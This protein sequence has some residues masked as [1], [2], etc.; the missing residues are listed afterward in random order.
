MWEGWRR[1][2]SPYPDPG[3]TAV[4]GA[5]QPSREPLARQGLLASRAL[6]KS[7]R[8]VQAR[9]RPAHRIDDRLVRPCRRSRASACSASSRAQCVSLPAQSRNELRSKSKLYALS[10]RGDIVFARRERIQ[11]GGGR[12]YLD[13]CRRD[14]DAPSET[15]ADREGALG[16]GAR[17]FAVFQKNPGPER[18]HAVSWTACWATV[19]L[20][21]QPPRRVQV[22]GKVR[23]NNN[24]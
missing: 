4:F 20:L 1:E 16:Y 14:S 10:D 13:V 22:L 8:F 19:G 6:A 9:W 7:R 12:R 17:R 21:T 24:V 11:Q 18:S 15:L 5:I 23:R 2:A 3:S